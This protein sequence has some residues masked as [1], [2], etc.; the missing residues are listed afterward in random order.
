MPRV[1]ELKG[2]VPEVWDSNPGRRRGGGTQ[3]I[4]WATY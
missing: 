2:G 1:P 3:E 4:K